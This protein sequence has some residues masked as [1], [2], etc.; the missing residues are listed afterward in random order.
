MSHALL[1]PWLVGLG[2]T[3]GLEALLRPPVAPVWRRPLATLGVHLGTWSLLFALVVLVV[4][5]P[6]FALT[7][8]AAL[9][10]V[11]VQSSNTKWQT[12]R[13]PFL[14]QDFEYFLDA[15]R[16][17][18]LYVPFFGIGLA[19]GAIAAGA[20]AIGGF[21]IL[22]PSAVGRFGPLA[23]LATTLAAA[24]LS[25][26]PLGL[27]L[28]RLPPCSLA[29]QTDLQRL[30]LFSA[31]WAYGRLARQP[32]SLPQQTPFAVADGHRAAREALPH[33]VAV[34]SE[35]FFDPRDWC[36]AIRPELLAH[37]D[38]MV[39]AAI[40]HGPLSVPAWGANTVRTEAAFLTGLDDQALGIHRFNPYH[41]LA[42]RSAPSLATSLRALGY[43][44]VC[45]HPYPASFYARDRV[46]PRLGFDDFID[47][48]AFDAAD[49]CGQYIGDLA[50]A[51]TVG[52]LLADHDN[53]PLFIFVITME[54]HGPLAMDTLAKGKADEWLKPKHAPLPSECDEL[55]SYLAHL[56][57]ADRMTDRL[58]QALSRSPR[59]GIL[60]WYGDH[61]PIMP[62]AYRHF[63]LP[64]GTTSY[65]LWS[66]RQRRG[67]TRDHETLSAS[68]LGYRLWQAVL[69]AA[70]R[71]T[72]Q[73]VKTPHHQ[74]QA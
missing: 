12:L 9:Q 7:V 45:V 53:S 70:T 63:G 57:N 30:G 56:R 35:S 4:Q 55:A 32:V 13:E 18:R 27:G 41:Q 52:K 16:H 14:C 48:R 10:L 11:V 6:W 59:E 15:L 69:E 74:E 50:V 37:Y 24:G 62:A 58:R 1:W 65:T 25:A 49:Y 44:T 38:A 36:P 42:K 3:L 29:P 67:A 68:H 71:A 22:E 51:D 40:A 33:V 47:I 20:L 39:G 5:R 60:C 17:P 28:A 26:L 43:R 73:D 2:L 31:L 46:M 23:F 66:T 72:D 8:I 64:E 34:Q 61:V 21:L 54:N 19:L